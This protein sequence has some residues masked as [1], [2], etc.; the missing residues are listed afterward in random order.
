[1]R[2]F[3]SRRPSWPLVLLFVSLGATAIAAIEAHRTV[4]S[5]RA[6]AEHALRDYAAFAS[7]S[8]Q[9]HLRESMSAAIR[10]A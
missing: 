10:E 8:Y 2:A 7:W 3:L 6:L 4:R 5:Q 1:M 9:Q